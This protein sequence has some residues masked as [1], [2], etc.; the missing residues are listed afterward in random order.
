[1][2]QDIKKSANKKKIFYRV[3]WFYSLI[4]DNEKSRSEFPLKTRNTRKAQFSCFFKETFS[5]RKVNEFNL[6]FLQL[7]FRLYEG[8]NRVKMKALLKQHNLLGLY[9]KK[10]SFFVSIKTFLFADWILCFIYFSLVFF[11]IYNF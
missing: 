6:N 5:F 8:L 3:K 9:C 11:L 2:F 7:F 1:M 4:K 10:S